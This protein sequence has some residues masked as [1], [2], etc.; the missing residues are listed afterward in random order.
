VA[1]YKLPDRLELVPG[2]PRTRIGKVDRA[3]LR[4]RALNA[5]HGQP[6]DQ[7]LAGQRL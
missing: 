1:D 6:A 4:D 5:D 2:L 7:A 3:A